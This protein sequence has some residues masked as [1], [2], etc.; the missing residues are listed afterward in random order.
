V[1]QGLELELGLRKRGDV[2]RWLTGDDGTLWQR[3]STA[4]SGRRSVWSCTTRT[5]S[6][7]RCDTKRRKKGVDMV[8]YG[9]G[10]HGGGTSL[11]RGDFGNRKGGPVALRGTPRQGGAPWPAHGD[12]EHVR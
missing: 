12:G 11:M 3:W 6:I 8:A 7:V 2:G 9:K 4:A 1:R 10:S 5:A